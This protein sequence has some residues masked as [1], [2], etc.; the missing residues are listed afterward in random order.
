[1][2]A[3]MDTQS[4]QLSSVNINDLLSGAMG[5]DDPDSL[6]GGGTVSRARRVTFSSGVTGRRLQNTLAPTRQAAT[7]RTSPE[8]HRGSC[9]VSAA[10]READGWEPVLFPG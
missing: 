9:R 6:L 1:M 5:L 3:A 4:S 7:V 8:E 2:T 10:R